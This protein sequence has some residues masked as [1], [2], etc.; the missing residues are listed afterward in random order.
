MLGNLAHIQSCSL[1]S[2]YPISVEL[3]SPKLCAYKS[4]PGPRLTIKPVPVIEKFVSLNAFLM[5]ILLCLI[6]IVT[7][8]FTSSGV[9]F[10][11]VMNLNEDADGFDGLVVIALLSF[12][13]VTL[14]D[15][16]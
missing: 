15:L 7:P 3:S 11:F 10:I 2:Y 14:P 13:A 8:T 12:E 1:G 9:K 16:C 4:K 5:Y 6:F